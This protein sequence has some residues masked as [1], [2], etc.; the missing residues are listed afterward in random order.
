MYLGQIP[1]PLT[2]AIRWSIETRGQSLRGEQSLHG[3]HGDRCF[4]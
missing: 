3:E 4:Y 2:M 1:L